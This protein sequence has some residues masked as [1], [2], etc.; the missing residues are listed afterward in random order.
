MFSRSV[1]GGSPWLN[2]AKTPT[3]ATKPTRP[4][5]ASVPK[6]SMETAAANRRPGPPRW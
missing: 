1:V 4:T 2:T 3:L 5:N 6:M